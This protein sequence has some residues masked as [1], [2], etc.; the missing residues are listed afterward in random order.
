MAHYQAKFFSSL[1]RVGSV[2]PTRAASRFGSPK[3]GAAKTGPTG[4]SNGVN[5]QGDIITGDALTARLKD[6]AAD[7]HIGTGGGNELLNGTT[8]S[9]GL[10]VSAH[11]FP[12]V[13]VQITSN[14]FLFQTGNIMGGTTFTLEDLLMESADWWVATGHLDRSRDATLTIWASL[15][16][17]P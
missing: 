2:A 6:V 4:L 16:V 9:L 3:L 14:R 17:L 11:R 15:Q 1:K 8:P 5:S 7:G 12:E 10:D 13:H